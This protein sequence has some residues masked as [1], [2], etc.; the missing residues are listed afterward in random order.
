VVSQAAWLPIVGL[1]VII[2]VF[3]VGVVRV[4]WKSK[5]EQLRQLR[6]GWPFVGVVGFARIWRA[7]VAWLICLCLMAVGFVALALT[8]KYPLHS[9]GSV[10]G[11]LIAALLSGA[12]ALLTLV[13]AFTGRPQSLVPPN[14]RGIDLNKLSARGTA[15]TWPS[16]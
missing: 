2:A 16:S 5:P 3:A 7:Q 13:V 1:S 9:E 15:R 10:I 11:A 12:G 4:G 8:E 14:L 6:R